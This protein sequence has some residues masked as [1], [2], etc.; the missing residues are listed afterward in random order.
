MQEVYE[1]LADTELSLEMEVDYADGVLN[2]VVGSLG[3]FVL[4]KQAPNLQIWLS[5]PVSGPL[6][7]DFC[8]SSTS[9]QNSRDQHDLL[10]RL[11]DGNPLCDWDFSA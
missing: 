6:R 10:E 9:W 4:N 1:D 3:T 11:A 5:S 2:V 8:A 7:Y